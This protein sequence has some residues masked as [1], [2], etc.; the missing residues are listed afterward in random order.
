[1][2]QALASARADSYPPEEELFKHV[3]VDNDNR[4]FFS[5]RFY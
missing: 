1:M 5:F 2:N 3:Y 4:L